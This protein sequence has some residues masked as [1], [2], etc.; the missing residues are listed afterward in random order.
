VTREVLDEIGAGE[1]PSKLVLNKADRVSDELQKE[2]REEF[3][4]AILMSARLPADIARLH[5]E[6]VAFFERD[7]EEVRFVVPYHSQRLVALL[8]ER[9]RVLD[10]RYDE[11]GTEVHVRARPAV[12]RSLAREHA[13]T[14]Q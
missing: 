8:H 13:L 2:L 1:R 12:L 9:C 3:P 10:E 7:M 5:S 11:Q 14:P 4:D 6:I